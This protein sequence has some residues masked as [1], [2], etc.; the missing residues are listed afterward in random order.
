MQKE[1]IDKYVRKHIRLG[2]NTI[3]L[4]LDVVDFDYKVTEIFD[5]EDDMFSLRRWFAE[6]MGDKRYR[7]VYE[8]GTE[9]WYKGVKC[10]SLNHQYTK[11]STIGV[12]VYLIIRFTTESNW[13][14][15]PL[16]GLYAILLFTHRWLVR[17]YYLRK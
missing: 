17:E 6:Q 9:I 4:P 5:M 13:I 16:I 10:N 11:V 14:H 2:R 8:D 7:V 12:V 15:F 3:H 1:L